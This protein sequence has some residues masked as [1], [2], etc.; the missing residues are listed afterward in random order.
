M[1]QSISF[2]TMHITLRM[3]TMLSYT[4]HNLEDGDSTIKVKEGPFAEGSRD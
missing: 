2:G 1:S 4:V 3:T